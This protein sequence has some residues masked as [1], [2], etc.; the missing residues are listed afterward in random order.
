[1]DKSGDNKF[2]FEAVKA[3]GAAFGAAGESG[4]LQR[5]QG[6]GTLSYS[7][8][9]KKKADRMGEPATL[10]LPVF[11]PSKLECL[12][13][14]NSR[15]SMANAVMLMIILTVAVSARAQPESITANLCDVLSSPAEYN[16]KVV[17]VEGVISPSIH[18]LFLSSPRCRQE[19][20]DFTTQAV[21]P[22]SWETP[23]QWQSI[24]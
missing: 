19:N 7:S 3:S 21:L 5:A 20:A 15:S 6:R 12:K 11:D 18:S 13:M 22:A 10:D 2:T 16:H 9:E 24:A 17:S 8:A 1:M 23:T 14:N 4:L